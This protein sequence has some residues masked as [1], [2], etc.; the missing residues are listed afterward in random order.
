MAGT[1]FVVENVLAPSGGSGAQEIAWIMCAD[2]AT[3]CQGRFEELGSIN[4]GAAYDAWLAGGPD[5][6]GSTC[7][8]FVADGDADDLSLNVDGINSTTCFVRCARR[9]GCESFTGEGNIITVEVL[10]GMHRLGVDQHP[11]VQ[12][13]PNPTHGQLEVVPA[14]RFH[15]LEGTIIITNRL[16]QVMMEMPYEVLD[17][18]PVSVNVE[19]LPGGLY[20]IFFKVANRKNIGKKFVI[21]RR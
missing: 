20:T 19:G 1:P 6:I 15:G 8:M 9:A 2:G 10:N 17:D 14:E 7:W 11:D 13:Y 21:A 18:N 16:G 5:Q 12:V 4:V 3:G